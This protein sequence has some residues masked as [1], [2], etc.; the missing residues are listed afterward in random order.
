[1]QS[2]AVLENDSMNMYVFILLE[3]C[4]FIYTPIATILVRTFLAFLLVVGL[5]QLEIEHI[6]KLVLKSITRLFVKYQSL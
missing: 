2:C 1:M 3:I 4:E 6:P 5:S